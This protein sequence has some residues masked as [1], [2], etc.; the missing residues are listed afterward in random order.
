MMWYAVK[1]IRSF[2]RQLSGYFF[3][4]MPSYNLKMNPRLSRVARYIIPV[5]LIIFHGSILFAQEISKDTLVSPILSGTDSVV[6]TAFRQTYLIQ[7][8]PASVAHLSRKDFS[9]LGAATMLPA[10]N[11]VPGVRM[12]ER[13]PGSYRFSIRGSLLRSPFGVRN[14]KVYLNQVPLTDAGGNTYLNLL[15]AG[16]LGEM[17]IL[18]GPA[19]SSYG[20]GTG[21]VLLLSSKSDE[22]RP[23]GT[24]IR[25]GIAGGSFNLFRQDLSF[26]KQQSKSQWKI[27]Q[28]H[29]QS[30]GYREQTAFRRD[31][32][33]F[34][35]QQRVGSHTFHTQ[36]I[37]ANLFYQ[38]PGGLTL[39]Q[40]QQNPRQA[41]PATTTLPGAVTQ[42]TSVSN[43]T[44]I[45]SVAHQVNL[46]ANWNL[47]SFVLGGQ[48][49]FSNPFIT[50]YEQR[51]EN[52]QGAGT[53][54]R[55]LNSKQAYKLEWISGIEWIRQRS[56]VTNHSNKKGF[57]DTLQ[58]KDDLMANQW[59]AYTQ[60]SLQVRE[61][62]L[63]AGLSI[64]N[65][66]FSFERISTPGSRPTY[67]NLSAIAAPRF[68]IS[69]KIN[70]HWQ[71]QMMVARGFSPPTLAEIRPS[72]GNFY[73]ELQPESGWNIE[74]GWRW[75]IVPGRLNWTASLYR[76]QL[77]QA[78]VRRN[79]A[80]GAEFFI[81]AGSTSQ[82]GIETS[83]QWEIIPSSSVSK[84][85]LSLQSGYSFQPYQFRQ[86][87]Q[88]TTN[89]SGKSLT[90]VPRDILTVGNQLSHVKGFYCHW[91]M[92]AT[93][94]LP[95]N[96]VND[97]WAAPYQLLQAEIGWHLNNKGKRWHLFISA[98]NLL[99]QSYSLGNDINAAGR[100]F[101]NPAPGISFLAGIRFKRLSTL[102]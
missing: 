43:E 16:M 14:V 102:F 40:F 63:E 50:N 13:S 3:S 71:V 96:D 10:V 76:F 27:D 23:E 56:D 12:E 78:I 66:R 54:I 45:V 30:S 94:T 46:S 4:S 91:Q 77:D 101:Y 28:D 7:Q 79:N 31:A 19:A 87:Q 53:S 36:I 74:L 39:A 24:Q 80:A 61:W 92:N 64:N 32:L 17:D 85:K 11:Q 93:S 67:Q 73:G 84:W 90:G 49:Q 99:N 62:R 100:R 18:K 55:Y 25:A 75:N 6:V 21:G 1:Y 5:H 58:F 86:Y 9:F 60:L 83:L 38:T 35:W 2:T 37:Y 47:H 34:H 8:L 81:N 48:T 42:N 97:E 51:K 65:Q 41:R 82:P 29:Q 52:N 44:V 95:L 72:D 69:R 57:P 22:K 70:S 33:A 98:D 88:G 15:P 68:S 89:L 59:F 26:E 20:A